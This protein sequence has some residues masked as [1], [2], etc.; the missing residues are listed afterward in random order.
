MEFVRTFSFEKGLFGQG[1]RSK[2][3]VGIGFAD[4]STLGNAKNVKLRFDATYM[5]MAADG[6][7]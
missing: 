6:K 1:A 3:A 2:D 5:Q 7:L 4:G